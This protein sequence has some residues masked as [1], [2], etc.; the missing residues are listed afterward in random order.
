MFRYQNFLFKNPFPGPEYTKMN[1]SMIPQEVIDQYN[2]EKSKDNKGWCYTRIH[3]GMYVLKQAGII[4]NNE[5]QKTLETIR[6]C[7]S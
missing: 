3:K 2:I 6:L 1:I 7:T 4:A 5:L